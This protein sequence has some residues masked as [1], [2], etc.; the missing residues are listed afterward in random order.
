[1]H[2]YSN[3]Q[4]FSSLGIFKNY[5]IGV[6]NCVECLTRRLHSEFQLFRTDPD[7][8][9]SIFGNLFLEFFIKIEVNLRQ[10]KMYVNM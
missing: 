9:M 6:K 7:E 2:V 4:R 10:L 1:M 5:K 3:F 8:I